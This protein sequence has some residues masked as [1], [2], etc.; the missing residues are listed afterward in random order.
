MP[1]AIPECASLTS[2][3]QSCCGAFRDCL[4]LS[5]ETA[6]FLAHAMPLRGMTNSV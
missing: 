3:L 2:V 4:S 5:L 6:Q 1:P